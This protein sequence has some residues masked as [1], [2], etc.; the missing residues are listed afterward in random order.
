MIKLQ[1]IR[2][3]RGLSQRD[4]AN[5]SGVNFRTIQGYEQEQ[6]DINKAS[7]ITLYKLAKSLNCRMEELLETNKEN[8]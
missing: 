3:Q 8:L 7:G 6:K 5:L 4:L 2:K 1:E